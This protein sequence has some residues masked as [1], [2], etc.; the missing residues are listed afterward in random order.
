MNDDRC[1]IADLEK[2]VR[3]QKKRIKGFE[4]LIA[5]WKEVADL[6]RNT[7]IELEKRDAGW[8]EAV[9][10]QEATLQLRQNLIN[11]REGQIAKLQKALDLAS[12]NEQVRMKQLAGRELVIIQK[13]ERI[14]ELQQANSKLQQ[15]LE[16]NE[17]LLAQ[18]EDA[19]GSA[20]KSL[21]EALTRALNYWSMDTYLDT[22]DYIIAQ[23]LTR[24][25]DMLK[26]MQAVVREWKRGD[27]PGIKTVTTAHLASISIDDDGLGTIKVED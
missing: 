8:R 11:D 27:I 14:K 10:R 21:V 18:H 13:A 5:D 9:D 20:P 7:I 25:L 17:Q 12:S 15:D 19:A 26:A 4:G 22:P 3:K 24:H 23:H 6:N 2:Q 16:Y 1:Y